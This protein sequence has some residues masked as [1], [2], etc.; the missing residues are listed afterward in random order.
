MLL[1][2]AWGSA[3]LGGA[4]LLTAVLQVDLVAVLQAMA[5]GV[6]LLC[7]SLILLLGPVG[8]PGYAVMVM[9]EA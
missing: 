3:D 2:V 5:A 7:A 1:G 6:A 9:A 4:L 8:C